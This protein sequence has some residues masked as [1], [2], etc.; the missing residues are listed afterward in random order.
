MASQWELEDSAGHAKER[1]GNYSLDGL[2]LAWDDS[3]AVRQ[4]LRS[5][6]RLLMKFDAK[7]K[8]EMAVHHVEKSIHNVRANRHVLSP[9]LHLVRLNSLLLPSIDRLIEEVKQAYDQ[10]SV[11]IAGEICYHEAWSIRQL[12]SLLKG[13]GG[14]LLKQ[15]K[16]DPTKQTK[17]RSLKS[18]PRTA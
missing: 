3:A 16:L 12:I 11:Q 14:R 9:L 8:C 18:Y 17:E 1:V 7:L 10:N 4:R 15:I 2:A 6:G 5:V 13:E